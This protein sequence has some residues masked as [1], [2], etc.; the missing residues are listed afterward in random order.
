MVK[1]LWIH[2]LTK[3][4]L[5]RARSSNFQVRLEKDVREH[6]VEDFVA[7][8]GNLRPMFEPP[9]R[10]PKMSRRQAAEDYRRLSEYS[11][12]RL[13]QSRNGC[14]TRSG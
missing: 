9:C 11:P 6:V 14:Q 8:E 2:S 10:I 12:E 13:S 7:R 3:P 5:P 1:R 4:S